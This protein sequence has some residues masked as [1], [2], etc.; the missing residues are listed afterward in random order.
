MHSN[1]AGQVSM[2]AKSMT[3]GQAS[4]IDWSPRWEAVF[5]DWIADQLRI[6]G[7]VEDFLHQ[8]PPTYRHLPAYDPPELPAWLLHLPEP[9]GTTIALMVFADTPPSPGD[10]LALRCLWATE[11]VVMAAVVMFPVRRIPRGI[12]EQTWMGA[13][14]NDRLFVEV[15]GDRL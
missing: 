13:G 7:K 10:K 12:V 14:W 4:R 9:D 11:Y 1:G 5:N 3:G 8:G 6:E 2:S 15:Q